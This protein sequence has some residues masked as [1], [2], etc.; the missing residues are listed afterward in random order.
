MSPPP[1]RERVVVAIDGPAGAGKSSASKELARRLGYRLLDTGALYR[2]VA[3]LSLRRGVDWDDPAA[4]AAVARDLDVEF[5]L[6]GAENR[7]FVAG[8]DVSA[9]IRTEQVSE[10][11][12]RVSSHPEVREAL[13]E[14]QRRLASEG[15]VVA[16]GRDVG[17]VVFPDAAA[18]F[19]L[20]A[21]STVRAKRRYEELSAAGEAADLEATR[22]EIVRRDTR[23]TTR[24]AAP[25]VE[26]PDAIRVD[27]TDLSLEAVVDTML[28]AVRAR[29]RGKSP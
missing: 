3:L 7:V 21:D 26:A 28:T 22:D 11:A 14:L 8:E 13:L 23:D 29:E 2:A 5:R 12:S 15:G 25:L 16:E 9:A 4:A 18:K 24:T 19:F 20:T 27:S 17:T 1:S 10:G 6:H